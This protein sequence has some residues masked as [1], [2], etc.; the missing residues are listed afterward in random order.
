MNK[1]TLVVIDTENFDKEKFISLFEEE[2]DMDSKNF[3]CF[4]SAWVG[5]FSGKCAGFVI[6]SY[7]DK[8]IISY[9]SYI[10]GWEVFTVDRNE[11]KVVKE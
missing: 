7:G 2:G 1:G 11:I 5:F 6:R 10:G 4:V 8:V 3:I 9:F